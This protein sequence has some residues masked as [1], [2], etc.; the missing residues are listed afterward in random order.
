[1]RARWVLARSR[2]LRLSDRR[3]FRP[4]SVSVPIADL[5]SPL[6]YDIEVRAEYFTFLTARLDRYREDFAGYVREAATTPYFT[7]FERVALPRYRPDIG[8]RPDQVWKAFEDRVR[9]STQLFTDFGERGFDATQ[10]I[11]LRTAL[12]GATTSTGKRVD[13]PF[14]AG[15]GCH[16]L[17]LLMLTGMRELP[18]AFYRVRRRPHASVIDNTSLLLRLV[19]VEPDR[20]LRYVA[21][22]YLPDPAED[23]SFADADALI[24]FVATHRPKRVAEL[25]QVLAADASA[26]VPLGGPSG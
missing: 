19:P 8:Q 7:W 18:P 11:S 26:F 3:T 5:V 22:G 25:R 21:Q 23:R 14:Y 16:R 1:M 4:G 6:R 17:A 13:R 12:P 24:D 15:D 10:P 9:R 20:Y 2:L